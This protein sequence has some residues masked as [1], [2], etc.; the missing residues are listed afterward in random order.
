MR[1]AEGSCCPRGAQPEGSHACRQEVLSAPKEVR[2]RHVLTPGRFHSFRHYFLTARPRDGTNLEAVRELASNS[3]LL[4]S[5]RCLQA[6]GADLRGLPGN[7]T[8]P[9]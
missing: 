6:S 7:A 3:K 2:R 8:P 5:L 1:C 9:G 4:T